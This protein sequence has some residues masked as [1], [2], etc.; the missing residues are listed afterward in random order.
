MSKS[1]VDELLH[2]RI[3]LYGLLLRLNRIWTYIVYVD[4]NGIFK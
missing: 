1:V 2:C 3:E 4:S